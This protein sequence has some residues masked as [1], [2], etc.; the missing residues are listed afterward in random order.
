MQSSGMRQLAILIKELVP[1]IDSELSLAA[2]QCLMKDFSI[3][4]EKN[5]QIYQAWVKY[6]ELQ[7]KI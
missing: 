7:G 4:N 2:E 3:Q 5:I 1:E 6:I